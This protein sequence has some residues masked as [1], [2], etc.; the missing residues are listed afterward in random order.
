MCLVRSNI[1]NAVV[2]WLVEKRRK[3]AAPDPARVEAAPP[4]LDP[5]EAVILGFV[6]IAVIAL[7]AFTEVPWH[8]SKTREVALMPD[9][10]PEHQHPSL[11]ENSDI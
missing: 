7:V 1:F 4:G 8:A 9:R 10:A 5:K 2:A 11:L 6:E 3:K